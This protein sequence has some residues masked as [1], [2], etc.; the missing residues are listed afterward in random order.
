MSKKRGRPALPL[1]EILEGKHPQYGTYALKKR[2]IESGILEDKC[3][4]CGWAEKPE[5]QPITP[6]ELDHIDGNPHNHVRSNLR[7]ICPNCHSMTKNYRKR[8]RLDDK[9]YV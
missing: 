2:L 4:L 3:E 7:L 8:R 5:S 1:D 6:C 9:N